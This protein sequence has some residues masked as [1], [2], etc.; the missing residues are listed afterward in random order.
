M[1][2]KPQNMDVF[3]TRVLESKPSITP[4][5]NK[6]LALLAC[7]PLFYSQGAMAIC[8]IDPDNA[9]EF[10][11]SMTLDGRTLSNGAMISDGDVLRLRPGF[12]SAVQQEKWSVWIDL[13]NDDDFSDPNE[14]VF[15]TGRDRSSNAIDALLTIPANTQISNTSMR[16]IMHY[17]NVSD[18][19]CGYSSFGDYQ[20]ITVSIEA[21]GSTPGDELIDGVSQIVSGGEISRTFD[22]PAGVNSINISIS[23]TASSTGDA[24]LYVKLGSMPTENDYDC[25]PYL[26]GSNESCDLDAPNGT[27]YVLVKP[28]WGDYSEVVLL[29]KSS[30]MLPADKRYE[31]GFAHL[32]VL[33]FEFRDDS[34]EWSDTQARET[35]DKVADYFSEQSYGRFDVTYDLSEPIIYI[36]ESRTFYDNNKSAWSDLY[37]EKI[38]ELGIDQDNP[39]D[40]NLILVVA[41][42][43]GPD[44]DEINHSAA[45]PILKVYQERV[46]YEELVEPGLIAHE[47]GHAVGLH[48][49]KAIEGNRNVFGVGDYDSESINYGNVFS[50]MGMGAY[51]LEE[52]NL[53]Y[54]YYFK[55]WQIENEVEEV[56]ASDTYRI[57][58]HDQGSIMGNLGLRLHSGNGLYT[59]WVEYR[60]RGRNLNLDGVL[61]NLEGYFPEQ[62]IKTNY[63]DITSYLLDMTPNSIPPVGDELDDFDDAHLDIGRSF[64]DEWG[65]FT[66]TPIRTGGILGTA[67]AWIEVEVDMH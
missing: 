13:N 6:L 56:S 5:K 67:G 52:F 55:Q 22:V 33:R 47:M 46:I 21:G 48:H 24:D 14:M 10:I 41:P 11:S 12:N 60:T 3:L 42:Q 38:E 30:D 2:V 32:K 26:S 63:W 49:S 50:L 19:G 61:I 8:A 20:D 36:D 31:P 17:D 35:L 57:Y 29:A 43:I 44:G 40:G 45:P 65:G 9:E 27:Y 7:L 16:V 66:I 15:T 62:S 34:L 28:Y 25:R 59:Y 18:D 64:T 53:L 23:A 4:Y 39:G 54:K 37:Y 58:A 51:D 1:D